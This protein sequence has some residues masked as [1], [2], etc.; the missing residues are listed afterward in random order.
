MCECCVAGYSDVGEAWQMT[1]FNEVDIEPMILRLY[2]QVKPFYAQL[3]AYVRRRLMDVYPHQALDARGPIPAHLLG[4]CF[5]RIYSTLF[6]HSM[7][8]KKQQTTKEKRKLDTNTI[9]SNHSVH[10]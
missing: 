2:E 6:L 5:I 7:T 9:R 8:A 4:T 3:H 1:D 10:V